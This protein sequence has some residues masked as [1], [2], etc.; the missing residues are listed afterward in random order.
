MYL[1]VGL[2]NPGAQ[3][4]NTRHNVGFKI[5]DKIAS[6]YDFSKAA[7]KFNAHIFKGTIDSKQIFLI[8]PQTFMNDSGK[9]VSQFVNFFKIPLQQVFIIYDDIDMPLGKFRIR[10]SGSDGGHNGIKSINTLIS[11]DYIKL[12]VGVGHPGNKDLVARYVLRP[13]D[14]NEELDIMQPL[15]MNIVEN[16][17]MLLEGKSE[18]LSSTINNK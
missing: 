11:N 12:K 13:F 14:K 17:S 10:S 4:E 9:S 16:L 3:Y 1:I 6:H 8:K 7:T 5:I 18:Q 2:G 15:Y